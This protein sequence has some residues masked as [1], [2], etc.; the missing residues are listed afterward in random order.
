MAI[1][2]DG[3]L[4]AG[5]DSSIDF[6]TNDF[7][8]A[9]W[10]YQETPVGV[11][12]LVRKGGPR[13][14][15]GFGVEIYREG[16]RFWFALNNGSGG[17][18][19][20]Y[21]ASGLGEDQ[22]FHLAAVGIYSEG[23]WENSKL[24]LNGEYTDGGILSKT[25]TISS[26][27]PLYLGV[28]LNGMLAEVMIF[29]RALSAEEILSLYHS[30][31]SLGISMEDLVGYWRMDEKPDGAAVAGANSVIDLSGNGNHGSPSS[32]ATYRAA[33]TKILKPTLICRGV[34]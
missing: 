16:L 10:V 6:T 7:T 26:P 29:F 30:R 4:D 18:A 24:Y 22:W 28:N 20:L 34:R 14:N 23:N 11:D 31:S 21:T 17:K 12:S 8:I 9:A 1:E 15:D 32:T 13:S 25:G 3:Y 19:A 2:F 5:D 33:P 27:Q